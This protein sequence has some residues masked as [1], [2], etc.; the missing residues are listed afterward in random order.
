[1]RSR[2]IARSLSSFQ[3][4]PGR[5]EVEVKEGKAVIRE[6][7][8]GVTARSIDWNIRMLEENYR[9]DDLALMVDPVNAKVCEKLDLNDIARTIAQRACVKAAYLIDRGSGKAIPEPFVRISSVEDISASHAV[10]LM[11]TKGGY[12]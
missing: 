9:V 8:P 1:M 3:G 2:H 12:L 5:G 6:R 11:C 4:V 10:L 7:N